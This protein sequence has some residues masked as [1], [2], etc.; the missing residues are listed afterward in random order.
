MGFSMKN[1]FVLTLIFILMGCT[2]KSPLAANNTLS[3]SE[4]QSLMRLGEQRSYVDKT[5]DDP[6]IYL[7]EKLVFK[8]ENAYCF[9][10]LLFYCF[11]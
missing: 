10:V 3:V 11:R 5:E 8:P 9:T 6:T 7:K 2:S 1:I 4:I